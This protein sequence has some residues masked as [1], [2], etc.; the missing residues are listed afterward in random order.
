MPKNIKEERY[1]WILPIIN[2][3][4]SIV[5]TAK[6][7]P[8][9]GRSIKRWLKAYRKYG[10]NG[11]EPKSTRPKTNPNETPIRIKERVIELRKEKKECALKLR[12]YLEDEGIFLHERTV[13]KFLKIEGLTK[14]YRT[15]KIQYQYVRAEFQSGELIEIDVKYVPQ[16]IDNKQYYQYTAI[17]VAT[18]WRYLLP[19]EEQ[20]NSNVILFLNEVM[21]MFPHKILAIKTDNHSTFTNRYTGYAKSTDPLCPRL[22]ILD[23]F[24]I[25]NKILH[26]LIDPGKPQQNTF[27]E[28]S[29]R[30][31]QESFYDRTSFA[32]FEDLKYKMRLWNMYYNDLRHIGLHG[33]TPNE[34][35][36][37][38]SF[39][40]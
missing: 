4:V 31:D 33:K 25:N 35:L 28:R 14:R 27:V 6:I 29:H 19:Y 20:S 13:G 9:S 8:H 17:D 26:Y 39:K 34:I 37:N 21:R 40:K 2:N 12:W 22:H 30:S 24:C 36:N 16:T 38:H 1:R 3:E 15:K 23:I 7:C 32:S 18:R 11:L 5:D 10:I